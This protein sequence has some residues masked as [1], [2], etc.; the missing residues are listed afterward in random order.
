MGKGKENIGEV[1]P[2]IDIF[3][4]QEMSFIG[5]ILKEM[6][7]FILKEIWKSLPKRD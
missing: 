6:Q 3:T 2:S 4:R 1:S 5:T 7:L